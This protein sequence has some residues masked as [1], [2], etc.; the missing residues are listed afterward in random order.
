MRKRSGVSSSRA[1]PSI[2]AKAPRANLE[3]GRR[4]LPPER[5]AAPLPQRAGGEQPRRLAAAAGG[6][7]NDA[8]HA[9]VQAAALA[10]GRAG[11]ADVGVV[12]HHEHDR[13]VDLAAVGGRELQV[14]RLGVPAE[15][16]ALVARFD[17]A[18]DVTLSELCVELMYP[19]NEA[20]A[21]WLSDQR[22]RR[23]DRDRP[24]T[25]RPRS[26]VGQG[27][28]ALGQSAATADR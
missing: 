6:G 18:N 12:R 4:E 25:E 8:E 26:S 19:G 21:R 15:L 5:A 10:G 27:S 3:L 11:A 22:R 23:N 7:G 14:E 28:A 20:A 2:P 13:P 24:T 17:S 9:A 16:F 1:S